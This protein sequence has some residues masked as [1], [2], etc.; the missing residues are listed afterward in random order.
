LNK[1]R[2]RAGGIDHSDV[3]VESAPDRGEKQV[4]RPRGRLDTARLLCVKWRALGYHGGT[5]FGDGWY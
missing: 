4:Q 2:E 1:K 3:Y 5:S